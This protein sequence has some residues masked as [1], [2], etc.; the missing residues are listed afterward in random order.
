MQAGK[1]ELHSNDSFP[2]PIS[3]G[4]GESFFKHR[5]AVLIMRRVTHRQHQDRLAAAGYVS[6]VDG[7][8]NTPSEQDKALRDY[9]D[10]LESGKMPDFLEMLTI[11]STVSEIVTP[12]GPRCIDCQRH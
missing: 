11:L 2:P 6:Q 12:A 7:S 1:P 5:K 4:A 10:K 3:S 8:S 9:L